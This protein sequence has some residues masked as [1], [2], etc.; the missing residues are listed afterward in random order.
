MRIAGKVYGYNNEL[1]L[2]TFD[3]VA[4]LPPTGEEA[5]VVWVTSLNRLYVYDGSAWKEIVTH[6][7]G[8]SPTSIVDLHLTGWLI[9][10]GSSSFDDVT[11]NGTTI[12]SPDVFIEDNIITLNY[13]EAHS[14]V[15]QYGSTA[16]VEIERGTYPN[17]FLL[18]DET[19][20]RWVLTHDGVNY[21]TIAT[22][23][24]DDVFIRLDGGS[25][26]ISDIPFGNHKIIDLHDPSD[27]QDAVNLRYLETSIDD[28]RI[29]IMD[30]IS[31]LA[32]DN[33]LR[34]DGTNKP[35]ADISWDFHK[36]VELSDPTG[37]YD[38]VNLHTLDIHI[39]NHNDAHNAYFL[40]LDGV[41][42]PSTDISW[43]NKKLKD[44]AWPVDPHDATNKE[45]VDTLFSS[46]LSGLPDADFDSGWVHISY[47]Y[48]RT[49]TITHNLGVVPRLVVVQMKCTSGCRLQF[50]NE[51]QLLAYSNPG[52]DTN[53]GCIINGIS[54]TKI[55]IHYHKWLWSGTNTRH[56]PGGGEDPEHYQHG[57][58]RVLAWK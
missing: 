10:D 39:N 24:D 32:I 47:L 3:K 23:A 45:Y 2:V 44:L 37:M 16:G 55:H 19:I 7:V 28:L 4:N 25:T 46:T 54:D 58:V 51:V 33:F 21:S 20:D 26:P 30:T 13:G 8:S 50:P 43:G 52:Y 40:R 27:P 6:Q 57:D 48:D 11:I 53:R 22:H 14:G 42:S 17:V 34:R 49:F 15:N 31:G 38:A 1:E 35:T 5:Q 41:N 56:I 18:Y 9:V 36:I 12:L 29:E